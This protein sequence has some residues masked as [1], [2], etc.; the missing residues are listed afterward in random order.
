[1]S[2]NDQILKLAFHGEWDIL[3][4]ILRNDPHLVNQSS[5]PKGYTPLHQAAW[6]GADLS[7]VAELLAIGADRSIKTKEGAI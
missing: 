2:I 1:M 3:L 7:V 5:E 6:Y 4:S